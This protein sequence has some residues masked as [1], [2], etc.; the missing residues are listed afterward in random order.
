MGRGAVERQ[1]MASL[2]MIFCFGVWQRQTPPEDQRVQTRHFSF[3]IFLPAE[4]AKLSKVEG[5]RPDFSFQTKVCA[6]KGSSSFKSLA[7]G[8]FLSMLSCTF[9]KAFVG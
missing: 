9:R 4:V 2:S 6:G 8:R 7:K 5:H 1:R 3:L